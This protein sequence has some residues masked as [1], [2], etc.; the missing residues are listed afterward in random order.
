M[1]DKICEGNK[2][3]TLSFKNICQ[4]RQIQ[5]LYKF[6]KDATKILERGKNLI[7]CTSTAS[8]KTLI[9]EYGIIKTLLKNKKAIYV[10]PMRALANEKY[11]EFKIYENFG[12]KLML[13]MGDLD[14]AKL[15]RYK[16]LR[17]D[18]LIATAEKLDSILRSDV[19]LGNVGFLIIDEIHFLGSSDRGAVYEI[20]IAKLRKKFPKVQ[21]LGLS[22]TIGNAEEIADWIN[23]ELI[24]SSFRPIPLIESVETKKFE[25]I[26]KEKIKQGS[27]LVFVNTKKRAEEIAKKLSEFLNFKSTDD[28]TD[29]GHQTILSALETPTEQC[30]LL[31][32]LIE[33]KVAFH[34]AGLV[35][36]QRT[37]IEENFKKGNI[38]IITATPTLAYGVNLPAHTVIIKDIKRYGKDGRMHYIPVL[39]YK[40]MCGRAGRPKY[41]K[42]GEAIIIAKDEKEKENLIEQ[43]I[44]GIPENIESYLLAEQNLRFHILAII[45]EINKF[46]DNIKEIMNFFELTYAFYKFKNIKKFKEKIY[47][48]LQELCE[49]K[50]VEKKLINFNEKFDITTLGKRI[51]ELYIDPLTAHNYIENLSEFISETNKHSNDELKILYILCNATEMPPLYVNRQEEE[52]IFIEMQK[53]FEYIDDFS[54]TSVQ[55][56]K[57]AKLFYDWINES[58]EDYI[59]QNYNVAPGILHTYIEIMEWLCYSAAEISKIL[60]FDIYKN[61]KE[62]EVRVKYGI[63]KEL[64]QLVEIKGIGRK[65][66]RILYDNGYKNADDLRKADV[67]VLAK[68]LKSKKIAGDIK[69]EVE[70]I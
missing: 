62:L 12:F 15:A 47:K 28:R 41:D 7:V 64:L 1:N 55:T 11:R 29:N 39:E 61:L 21:I 30:K 65:R 31:S 25:K 20:L 35:N 2:K 4:I 22:A 57:I 44:N 52:E 69:K 6:Q 24:K 17:F 8:G 42:F 70:M 58:D 54:Y 19:Q 63:K 34:H 23:A 56:F 3:S 16:S 38:K 33:K 68:I 36:E 67:D 5:K 14:A 27:I 46:N 40:Q 45:P 37:F 50:F 10:V 59:Y 49:W 26:V 60:K 66:A 9:A 43:Y 53:I 51:C 13:Q 32:S 18:I 48:T